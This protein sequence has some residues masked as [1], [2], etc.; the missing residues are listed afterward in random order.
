MGITDH[1]RLPT[2]GSILGKALYSLLFPA[3]FALAHLSLAAAAI[4]FL[5]AALILRLGLAEA[6][7]ASPAG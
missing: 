1:Q 6:D 3:A 5:P 2:Q 4:A 7:T